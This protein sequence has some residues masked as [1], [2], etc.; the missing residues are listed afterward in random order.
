MV[1]RDNCIFGKECVGYSKMFKRCSDYKEKTILELNG[2]KQNEYM[3]Y[4]LDN[5]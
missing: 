4:R 3:Q 1:L 5:F 2:E